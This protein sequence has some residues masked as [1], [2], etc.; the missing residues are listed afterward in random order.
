MMSKSCLPLS[1]CVLFVICEK[2]PVLHSGGLGR[3]IVLKPKPVKID[4]EDI[5]NWIFELRRKFGEMLKHWGGSGLIED[6]GCWRE[7]G[8]GEQKIV[9][10]GRGGKVAGRGGARLGEG[11]RVGPVRC[12]GVIT[13]TSAHCPP[14]PPLASYIRKYSRVPSLPPP[15]LVS[16]S[17]ATLDLICHILSVW[18][19]W[20]AWYP[21]NN[22]VRPDD[23]P[24]PCARFTSA[25]CAL[26]GWGS[27]Q[28]TL[29][30]GRQW[31]FSKAATIINCSSYFHSWFSMWSF[32]EIASSDDGRSFDWQEQHC[33]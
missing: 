14:P 20:N 9:G 10:L 8:R 12:S 5:S 24:I 22:R 25:G 15:L 1:L 29:P 6:G 27:A 23:L 32:C 28:P 30:T 11:G 3:L 19:L 4:S 18:C 16:I 2:K 13:F 31:G 21:V 33:R 17:V 7:E 26:F